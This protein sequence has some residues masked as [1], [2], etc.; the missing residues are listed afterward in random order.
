MDWVTKR[1]ECS[2]ETSFRKLK[3][4]VSSDV[5][6]AVA[7]KRPGLKFSIDATAPADRII[8]DRSAQVLLNSAEVSSVVFE[9]VSDEIKVRAVNPDRFLF[10]AKPRLS[11]A[12]ECLFNVTGETELQH[13]WQV[14]QKGLDNLFFGL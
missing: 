7:L 13:L 8:V 5:K 1:Y 11:A 14:S 3:E 9:L 10:S 2:L 4:V 6:A 12:G